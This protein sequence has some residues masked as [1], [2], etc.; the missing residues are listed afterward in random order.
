MSSTNY[1]YGAG[2]HNTNSYLASG[3]PFMLHEQSGN[4]NSLHIVLFPSITKNITIKND[5]ANPIL[6]A[7]SEKVFTG[8]VINLPTYYSVAAGEKMEFKV[9]VPQIY[10]YRP[11]GA[12]GS[13]YYLFCELT[14]IVDN[15]HVYETRFHSFEGVGKDLVTSTTDV[16]DPLNTPSLPSPAVR[17]FYNN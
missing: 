7:F 17:Q 9:R 6:I 2:F 10:I 8:G 4:A 1:G 11:T 5:G 3:Y 16:H 13:D 15:A 12:A 14:G